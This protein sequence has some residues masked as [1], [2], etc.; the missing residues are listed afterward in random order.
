M[1]YLFFTVLNDY[2]GLDELSIQLPTDSL[3][4]YQSRVD[5]DATVLYNYDALAFDQYT[6]EPIELDVY[7]SGKYQDKSFGEKLR[8]QNYDLHIGR[9]WGPVGE[10]LIFF[11]ALFGASLPLTGYYILFVVKRRMRKSRKDK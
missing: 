2:P 1:D 4:A 5:H 11:A 3:D 8:R 9:I 6:L 10:V 7:Y